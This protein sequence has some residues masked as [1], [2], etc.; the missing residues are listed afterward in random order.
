MSKIKPTGIEIRKRDGGTVYR[1]VVHDKATGKRISKTFPTISAA[2]SWRQDA[3]A[4]LR[5]GTLSA[6]RGPTLAAIVADWLED[7]RAGHARNRSGDP[8]K[9]AAIR[10]YEKE[11]RLRVLPEY[12]SVRVGDLRRS[13]MQRLVDR[14]VKQDHSASTV[15]CVVTALRAVFRYA[16]R[17][18]MLN[19][20]PTHKLELPAVRSK[21][22]RFCSSVEAAE[23]IAALPVADRALWATAFYAGLRR[24]ELTGLRWEDVDLVANEIRVERGWDAVEGDIASKS[25]QGHRKVPLPA[26]LHAFLWDHRVANDDP[27][28]CG[29]PRAIRSSIEAATKT[30]A[31]TCECGHAREAHDERCG[32][33]GCAC[34]RFAGLVPVTPHEARHTYASLMIAAGVNAKA[35]SVFMGHA[36]IAVTIDLYGHLMPGSEAEAAGLLDTYVSRATSPATSPGTTPTA[37]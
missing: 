27:R 18:D 20:D 17:R 26:I 31:S 29:S 35:L 21:P 4:A 37:A 12:G 10:G 23:L 9:P 28:V 13:H 3:Y 30:W 6:D 1:A 5:A 32:E 16:R 14:L 8:Y 36:N 34:S 24:G 19:D 33:S 25:R 11:L 7:A 2:K 22:R 15:Q